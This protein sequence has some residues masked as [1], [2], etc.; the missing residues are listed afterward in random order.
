M[1]IA[2][3]N[4]IASGPG[5]DYQVRQVTV[6]EPDEIKARAIAVAQFPG[7]NIGHCCPV[8]AAVIRFLK[9]KPGAAMGWVPATAA[10]A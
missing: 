4:I 5:Q 7:F 8:E 10:S 2:G 9:L 3:Y 1:R 6:A